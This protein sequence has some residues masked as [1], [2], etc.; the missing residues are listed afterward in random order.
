[1][2]SRHT[3]RWLPIGALLISLVGPGCAGPGRAQPASTGQ[4]PADVGS[5]RGDD[6]RTE[7]AP[8]PEQIDAKALLPLE[9]IEPAAVAP[10]RPTDLKPLP[11][12]AAEQIAAAETLAAEQRYTEASLELEKALRFAPNHPEIQLALADL[13]LRSGS[14]E[15]ARGHAQRALEGNPDDARTQMLLGSI[16]ARSGDDVSAL[17]S[18]RTALLCSDLDREP[19]TALRVRFELSRVLSRL[20]YWQAALEQRRLVEAAPA[21]TRA[22]AGLA[23]ELALLDA[24]LFVADALERLGRF[25]EAAD[26][27]QA[28]HAAEPGQEDL[29]LRLAR[30]LSRAGK[31]DEALKIARGI[32]G[33]Q[34]EVLELLAAIHQA[35]GHPE[36]FAEELRGRVAMK[37]ADEDLLL[38]IDAMQTAGHHADAMAALEERLS[39]GPESPEMRGRLVDALVATG[40]W[41]KALDNAALAVQNEP[42]RAAKWLDR[43]ASAA[44]DPA[45]VEAALAPAGDGA[46]AAALYVRGA[47]ALRADR[48]DAARGLFD[49]SLAANADFI[50]TRAALARL[51]RLAYRY[52]EALAVAARRN[53]DDAED[54]RLELELGMVNE[55]LDQTEQAELHF[56]AAVQLDRELSE[57]RFML[58]KTYAAMGRRNQAQQQLRLLLDDEPANEAAVELLAGMYLAERK[59]GEALK[60]YEAMKNATASP[61]AAARA[62]ALITQFTTP[63]PLVYRDSIRAAL[64]RGPAD[65]ATWVAL[66]ESYDAMQPAEARDAY[67]AA[68]KLDPRSEDAMLGLIRAEHDL[69]RFEESIRLWK[70]LLPRRPNRHAWRLDPGGIIEAQQAIEAWDGA[71]AVAREQEAREGLSDDVRLLYRRSIIMTLI[72]AE[73][74]DEAVAAL[75]AWITEEPGRAEWPRWLAGVYMSDDRPADA[76][77]VLLTMY[78]TQSGGPDTFDLL[79]E[80]LVELGQIDRAAQ[81]ALDRLNEDPDLDDH[82]DALITVLER[83]GKHEEAIELVR[84]K[85]ERTNDPLRFQD[86]LISLYAS[87]ERYDEGIELIDRLIEAEPSRPADDPLIT[88]LR[89]RLVGILMQAE[90]YEDARRWLAQWLLD[91]RYPADQF[92]WLTLLATTL[93]ALGD[94][95]GA[96]RAKEQAILLQPTDPTL[97][98]DL[99]Y[100]WINRGVRLDEAEPRIRMAV[101]RA[102][103]QGAYLDTYGWLMYKKG[104]F[105]EARLWLGRAF[106]SRGGKDPVIADHLGDAC[107]KAG[108]RDEAVRYWKQALELLEEP[109]DRPLIPDEQRVA[110]GTGAKIAAAGSGGEPAVAATGETAAEAPAAGPG[111]SDD[112]QPQRPSAE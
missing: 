76:L 46:T 88:A 93:D 32:R 25:G 31:T 43:L 99:A 62:E 81:L 30:A 85:L 103:R 91:A 41:G 16:Q 107:W 34:A 60:L 95:E 11:A 42:E 19:A 57:A 110:S 75:K 82:L 70:E 101:A 67:A 108:A 14:L 58:G 38:L 53:P 8:R 17:D 68:L 35:A 24:R 74:V 105:D 20:G 12:R 23:D 100:S 90:R 44:P 21:E 59:V 98:N 79:S 39:R 45:L 106:R 10:V 96:A 84:S 36:R 66:A 109:R 3:T 71:L 54:A 13:H 89:M 86:Q 4:S 7:S 97:N 49:R 111:R 52:D 28:L 83:A 73:R 55:L 22:A 50:P 78:E 63:D 102:P 51:H 69:L 92:R 9:R 48:P 26:A 80:A 47:V 104:R 5:A 37:P 33:R 29:A 94:P 77:P 61:M 15:R 2:P 27:L 87:E 64:E 56:R 1:M 72:E 112:D 40:S 6:R 65:A 18:L